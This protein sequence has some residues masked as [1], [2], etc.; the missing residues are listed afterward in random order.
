[1]AVKTEIIRVTTILSDFSLGVDPGFGPNP[2]NPG[3][4]KNSEPE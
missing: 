4:F 1:M 2:K 3:N